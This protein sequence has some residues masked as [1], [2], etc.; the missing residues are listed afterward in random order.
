MKLIYIE[1]EDACSHAGSAK[2]G[3]WLSEDESNDWAEN[4]EWIVRQ[5][6]FIIKETKRY[7]TIAGMMEPGGDNHYAMFGHLQKIPKSWIRKRVDLTKQI[8]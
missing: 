8:K 2:T 7:L 1:W 6:G 3:S 5:S 4:T